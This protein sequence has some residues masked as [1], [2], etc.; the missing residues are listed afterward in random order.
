M[1]DHDADFLMFHF[2]ATD[3]AQH[4]L[5][6]YVDPEHPLYEAQAA[7]AHGA[8]LKDIYQRIDAYVGAMLDR[9]SG[10]TTVFVMSD[11]GFGS[12]HYVVN[13]NMLLMDHGL[14]HLKPGVWTQLRA[15][16]FR[17]GLTPA[18]IWHLIERAGLQNYVWQIS[19]ST[20]NKIVSRFLSFDDVDWA[21]TMAY[22]IG[23]VGQIYINRRD[24]QPGGIVKP[25]AEYGEVVRKVQAALQELRHP[26]SGLPLVDR[27]IPGSDVA[28]GPY[29]E[30]GPD[31]HVVMDGYRTIAFPL[32]ASDGRLVTQQ[33]R[34]DSGSHRQHG[35]FI[36]WGNG[37]GQGVDIGRAHIADLAP[38][39]LHL[40]SV[41]VP[42]DMDGH[43]LE[44]VLT[45]SSPVVFDEGSVEAE[46]ESELSADESA[47]VESRL[48]ALG[49]LG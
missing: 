44:G 48:R 18:A 32:F 41:P 37:I 28:S 15:R 46:P 26:V 20:R 21:R 9:L 42:R 7:Q 39:I 10:E 25:G 29:A 33:I 49:Y 2:Q 8:I 6:K 3:I 45:G 35:I 36:A 22:S 24:R 17:A 11:H 14:L 16:L 23:H 34:G 38:T 5:W 1:S 43:V 19:K 31:L 27:V 40:M 4:A 12:L 13:L 30:L 47:E